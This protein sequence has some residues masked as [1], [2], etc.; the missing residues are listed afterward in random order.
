MKKMARAWVFGDNLNTDQITPGR[1]NMT[2][3]AA[4]LAKACL[5][6]CR[7]EFSKT[8]A[9]D[10]AIIAG[11]NFGCGSSRETAVMALKAAGI[12]VIFAKSFARIFFRNCINNGIVPAVADT[13]AIADG[14]SVQIGADYSLTLAKGRRIIP[15]ISAPVLKIVGEGGTIPYIR[16]HGI[17]SLASLFSAN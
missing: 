15:E 7:P 1:F 6:E 8:V 9:K 10:D 3:D 4:A 14:D 13:T 5:V 12:R 17:D 2:T 11:R 16:V